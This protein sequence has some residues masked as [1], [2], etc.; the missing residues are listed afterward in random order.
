MYLFSLNEF[1]YIYLKELFD[2]FLCICMISYI[3][4]KI[5]FNINNVLFITLIIAT[6]TAI[7]RYNGN[8]LFKFIKTGMFAMVN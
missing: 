5:D 7:L 2:V 4:P 3:N 1:L 6:T 8:D